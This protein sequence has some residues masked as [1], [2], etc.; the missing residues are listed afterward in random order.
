MYHS[1]LPSIVVC[2]LNHLTLTVGLLELGTANKQAR[3]ENAQPEQAA[4]HH[5]SAIIS[6][7]FKKE[8]SISLRTQILYLTEQI[9]KN[10]TQYNGKLL[11]CRRRQEKVGFLRLR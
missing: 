2:C 3:C 1:S 7:S 9:S 6:I 11:Q 10:P 4:I 5:P 8:I